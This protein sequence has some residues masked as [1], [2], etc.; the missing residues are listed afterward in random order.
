M[1]IINVLIHISL[2]ERHLITL[3][4]QMEIVHFHSSPNIAS[5]IELAK[6]IMIVSP[7]IM[8]KCQDV[9]VIYDCM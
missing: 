4:L 7:K 9:L 6:V 5:L 1:I 8:F 2:A 3:N